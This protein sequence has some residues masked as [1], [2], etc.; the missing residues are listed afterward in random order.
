MS[1]TFVTTGRIL[2]KINKLKSDVSHRTGYAI[3]V[4]TKIKNGGQDG[5]QNNFVLFFVGVG[6]ASNVFLTHETIGVDPTIASLPGVHAQ[7]YASLK[8]IR[9]LRTKW[10]RRKSY[11]A[12]PHI[13]PSF[14]SVVFIHSCRKTK[15]SCHT[16]HYYSSYGWKLEYMRQQEISRCRT[17]AKSQTSFTF[18]HFQGQTLVVALFCCN[19]KKVG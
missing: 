13:Y 16:F 5:G 7:L 18:L 6:N 14:F 15:N 3:R 2:A 11:S 10:R 4:W 12:F 1:V 8:K 9:K 19:S 17:S